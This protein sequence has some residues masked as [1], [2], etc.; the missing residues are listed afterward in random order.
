MWTDP[1]RQRAAQMLVLANA[2]WALSFPTTKALALLQQPLLPGS[3]SWFVASW[4]LAIR[5]GLAALLLL[6]LCARTLRALTLAEIEQGLGL[7]LFGSLGLVFQMDGLA[8]TSA[9]TSAFLTQF[10]CLIIPLFVAWRER[11]PPSWIV[12]ASCLLVI[13]GVG[14][15]SEI[16]WR[17]L[18]IGRGELETLIGSTIFTGQILWLQRPKFARNQVGNFTL[19]MFIVIALACLALAI[20][21]GNSS[22]HWLAA[23]RPPGA[24]ISLA[25]LTL[26]S[27]L[28]GYLLMNHWQPLLSATQAGLLYCLEPVFASGFALFLP[29]WFSV[30]CA[31]NY[32]NEQLH[33]GLFLGGGLITLANVLIQLQPAPAL[34][35]RVES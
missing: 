8:Y 33:A 6:P 23:C 34:V 32:P 26:F 16:D 13:A 2:C 28:G 29:G 21:T 20:A 19:V 1:K 31:M 12:V 11:R 25:I 9:S 27:T 14:I 10:Y 4:T 22:D 17:S 15:L 5:F 7:G 35:P 30:L 18:R 3:S 24:L